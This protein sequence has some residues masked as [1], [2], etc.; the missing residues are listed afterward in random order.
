MCSLASASI[1]SSA[2][3]NCCH[4]TSQE[5]G[6]R[7]TISR[8]DPTDY[9]ASPFAISMYPNPRHV[10]E[11]GQIVIGYIETAG[12]FC[13]SPRPNGGKRPAFGAVHR[14][15]R[16]V[17]PSAR[18]SLLVD[19]RVI[20]PLIVRCRASG[21]PWPRTLQRLTRHCANSDGS[22]SVPRVRKF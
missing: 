16:E 13:F 8:L 4:G 7:A 5:T 19:E 9:D 10:T 22:A 15:R 18:Q 1:R 21:S 6:P 17:E 12:V 2:S 3:G 14:E 11:H 20:V